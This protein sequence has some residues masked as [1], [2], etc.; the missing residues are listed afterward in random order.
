MHATM[1]KENR[2]GHDQEAWSTGAV[3]DHY[4]AMK[5]SRLLTAARRQASQTISFSDLSGSAL[6]TLRA[7]LAL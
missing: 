1:T 3:P 5:G 7:G 2:A 6:T 4:R